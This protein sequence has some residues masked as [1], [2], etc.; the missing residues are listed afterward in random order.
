M[1]IMYMFDAKA[2]NPIRISCSFTLNILLKHEE[3]EILRENY[4]PIHHAALKCRC[5][6]RLSVVYSS[7]TIH[8]LYTILYTYIYKV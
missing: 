2:T 6:G 8:Q 3:K 1:N 7:L 5:T 4:P